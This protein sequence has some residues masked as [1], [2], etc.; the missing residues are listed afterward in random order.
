MLNEL[1]LEVDYR[2]DRNNLVG[3]FYEPC[4]YRSKLYRRAVGYFSSH[5]VASAAAGVAA[6]V[7]NGG[8]IHLAASPNLQPED[9]VALQQGYKD[10]LSILTEACARDFRDIKD[11]LLKDRLSAL[12]W[13][14]AKGT[15]DIKLVIRLNEDGNFG[16]GIYH[17]KIGIFEDETKNRVAFSGSS[18]ETQGGLVDNFEAIDVYWSW[19]DPH[20][21]VNR[22]LRDFDEMWNNETTGLAIVDFSAAATEILAAYRSEREPD[23]D[24]MIGA[25][26]RK[27]VTKPKDDRWRHQDKALTAFLD[28][29]RGILEMATGTGKT[30]TALRICAALLERR[31]IDTI[32]V[33]TDGVDLLDQ[34]GTQLVELTTKLNRKFALYRHYANFHARDRFALNPENAILL[35]SRPALA[36]PLSALSP[37]VAHKTILIHDEVHRAGSAGNRV[38][39]TT[40]AD[41]VRFRLGLSAT[42]E[43]EYDQDGNAFIEEHIGPVL[44]R[45][46]LEEAILGGILAP[47]DYHPLFYQLDADDRRKLQ[48]V[49]SR[50]TSRERAGSPMS[51][52]EFWTELARV[53]KTSRAKLPVFEVF[54]AAH[55]QLLE[56]CII[57]VETKEY[58]ESV[59]EIVHRHRHDFH[60]YYGD[61]DASV[62]RRFAHGEIA[63]L[64]TCHR[65]S[66]GIDIRS[67]QS[68]ILFSSSRARLE[69]IQRMGRCLRVDPANPGKRA[70]VVDFIRQAQPGDDDPESDTER[71]QWLTTLSA[72]NPRL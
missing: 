5:G 6:L 18:N 17:E 61:D 51:N 64:I 71:C 12:A 37:A 67:L 16:R 46:G 62:L 2:S 20:G 9:I 63:C 41:P 50:R 42:P 66:E 30:R 26:A 19:D 33:T 27:P 1:K 15:L 34:W 53:H 69:T 8:H 60:T 29:E 39:L 68:V 21:R 28:K 40:L 65:L 49:F 52:E 23:W 72:L 43:R 14:V 54:I 24:H 36:S 4:L 11:A 25:G 58:G 56:N 70:S 13:L 45:F 7:V 44:F 47:F 31:L 48:N 55:P 32:I 22:K 59:L 35:I 3:D 38:S 10:R 57:F